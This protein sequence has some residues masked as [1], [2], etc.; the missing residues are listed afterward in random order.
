MSVMMKVT[1]VPRRVGTCDVTGAAIFMLGECKVLVSDM[2]EREK[3]G[4]WHISISHP[5]RYPTWDEI[6]SARY[7]LMPMSIDVAMYLPPPNEYVNVHS[8]CFH[9]WEVRR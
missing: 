9:L 1:D 8:N 2:V 7:Q 3:L 5:D 6:Y 4:G